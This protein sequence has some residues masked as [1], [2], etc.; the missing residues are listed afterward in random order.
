MECV[1][2]GLRVVDGR[3]QEARAQSLFFGKVAE[4][5]GIEQGVGGRV[6]KAQKVVV[7]RVCLSLIGPKGGS[8]KVGAN[9]KH[10]GCRHNHGLIEVGRGQSGLAFGAACDDHAVEL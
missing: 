7:A 9:G 6:Q 2:N 4:C 3:A 5:L 8:A 1:D 10:D